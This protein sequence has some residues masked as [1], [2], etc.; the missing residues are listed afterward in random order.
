MQA[1]SHFSYHCSSGQYVLCDLQGA[2]YRRSVVITDPVVHSRSKRY[3][4]TDMGVDG[5]LQFFNLHQCNAYCCASWQQ[6]KK[7]RTTFPVRRCGRLTTWGGCLGWLLASTTRV[8]ALLLLAGGVV[9][10][11]ASDEN[12]VFLHRTAV[13]L[14]TRHCLIFW[15]VCKP[16]EAVTLFAKPRYLLNALEGFRAMLSR[17]Q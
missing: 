4:P 15:Y 1:L 3:G 6:P 12:I 2:V 14:F 13:D 11:W 5:I 8:H 9:H 10:S 16:C 17:L 7:T